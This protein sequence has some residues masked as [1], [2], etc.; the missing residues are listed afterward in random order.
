[1]KV[2]PRVNFNCICNAQIPLCVHYPL[3]LSRK[4]GAHAVMY[5]QWGLPLVSCAPTAYHGG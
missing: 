3:H 4:Q 1:M 5:M 2:R